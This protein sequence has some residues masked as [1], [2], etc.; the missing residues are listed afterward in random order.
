MQPDS[1]RITKDPADDIFPNTSPRPRLDAG[2]CLPVFLSLYF[3][4]FYILF[5]LIS[6]ALYLPVL[7]CCFILLLC[8]LVLCL[9]VRLR[10]RTTSRF[11][12]QL[13]VKA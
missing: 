11:N 5:L 9:S 3:R 2:L 8:Q 10:L 7:F 1:G 13:R 12:L 4:L 6:A